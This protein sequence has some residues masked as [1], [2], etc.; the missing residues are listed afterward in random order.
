VNG[1]VNAIP[2]FASSPKVIN[3]ASDFLVELFGEAGMHSRAAVAVT[4]LPNDAT[5]ELQ[6]VI[7][8]R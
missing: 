6:M 3:G 8:T 5:V 4:G 7:E 2:G 1:Y